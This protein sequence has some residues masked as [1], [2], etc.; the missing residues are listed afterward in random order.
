MSKKLLLTAHWKQFIIAQNLIDLYWR[1]AKNVHENDDEEADGLHKRKIKATFIW[2][3]KLSSGTFFHSNANE[4]LVSFCVHVL[5]S[6]TYQS[7][8]I[9]A[10]YSSQLNTCAYSPPTQLNCRL[11]LMW[12]LLILLLMLLLLLLL[13]F[14]PRI[15]RHSRFV[16][17]QMND[18]LWVELLAETNRLTAWKCKLS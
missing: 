11:L 18:T 12:R 14:S 1:P 8:I 15:T 9:N 17:L 13:W 7:T 10:R 6:N 4:C 5:S 3:Y 16:C 2:Q